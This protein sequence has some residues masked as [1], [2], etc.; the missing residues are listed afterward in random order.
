LFREG[1]YFRN[2]RRGQLIQY[3]GDDPTFVFCV[4]TGFVKL[5]RTDQHN[6][7]VVVRLIGTCDVVGFRPIL[8]EEPVGTFAEAL[9][10]SELCI[11]PKSVFL[12]LLN[13]SPAL[14]SAILKYTAKE[15]RIAEDGWL[16]SLSDSTEHRVQSVLSQ[17]ARRRK[18]YPKTKKA[19]IT[20]SVPRVEIA[21]IVGVTPST[22]SRVLRGLAKR[23]MVKLH[24]RTIDLISISGS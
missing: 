1:C 7:E 22:V 11:I 17:L 6:H 2:F 19:T 10:A 9:E 8:G 5:Y 18:I 4:Q 16:A 13:S 24:P 12:N 21:R 15:W 23:G 3:Q 20:V 14:R